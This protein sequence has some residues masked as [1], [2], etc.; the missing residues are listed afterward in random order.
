ME[1]HTDFDVMKSLQILEESV[2]TIKR[3]IAYMSDRLSKVE[4]IIA[5]LSALTTH[6]DY[7]RAAVEELTKE[8]KELQNTRTQAQSSLRMLTWMVSTAVGTI[9]FVYLVM[10]IWD[11]VK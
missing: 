11:K 5:T 3:D 6:M 9:G 8:M 10:E 4:N 2:H 7:L 1:L